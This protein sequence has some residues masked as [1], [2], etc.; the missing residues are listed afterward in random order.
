MTHPSVRKLRERN[1][2]GKS[3]INRV[4]KAIREDQPPKRG[5]KPKKNK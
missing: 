3:K 2:V 4:L 1:K 5:P